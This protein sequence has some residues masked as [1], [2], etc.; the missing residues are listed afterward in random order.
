[1]GI[2]AVFS[3]LDRNEA[4]TMGIQA[5]EQP[6][7]KNW[8]STAAATQC[9][10]KSATPPNPWAVGIA[11]CREK[12][13]LHVILSSHGS[14]I[15]FSS[16]RNQRHA[17]HAML[18]SVAFTPVPCRIGRCSQASG[19]PWKLA[20]RAQAPPSFLPFALSMRPHIE[21]CSR[22]K[23]HAD[24]SCNMEAWLEE[25]LERNFDGEE[26]R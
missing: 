20:G 6:S 17:A 5:A 24:I 23:L 26:T 13:G 15:V 14:V 9:C 11:D 12:L 7:V 21:S 4:W 16:R 18:L 2:F 8:R 19:H 10:S 22:F 3:V 25:F 1:M